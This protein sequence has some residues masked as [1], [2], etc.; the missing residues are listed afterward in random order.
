MSLDE[1]D[2]VFS[3]G[4]E[5]ASIRARRAALGISQEKLA[6]LADCSTLS[7]RHLER[8][9]VY[10]RSEVLP[11]ILQALTTAETDPTK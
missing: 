9:R 2:T 4:T 7:V 8:G 3:I 10:A 11:R 1:P 5:Q 6:R